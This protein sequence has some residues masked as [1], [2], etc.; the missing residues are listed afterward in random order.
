MIFDFFGLVSRESRAL[1]FLQV[2][3]N[4]LRGSEGCFGNVAECSA[5]LSMRAVQERE[6]LRVIPRGEQRLTVHRAQQVGFLLRECVYQQQ[7]FQRFHG[8]HSRLCPVLRG[9]ANVQ[10]F[11]KI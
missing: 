11:Y 6:A 10:V 5:N 2:S 4:P 9:A 7:S 1:V 3:P 8:M